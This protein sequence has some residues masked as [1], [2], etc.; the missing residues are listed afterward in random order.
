MGRTLSVSMGDNIAIVLYFSSQAYQSWNT[1]VSPAFAD[2]SHTLTYSL[3]D[4]TSDSGF[5]YSPV[6]AATPLPA[7]FPLFASGLGA[8]TLFGWRRKRKQAA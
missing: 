2:F 6:A 7:A 3:T 5:D 4:Y 1:D 8:L